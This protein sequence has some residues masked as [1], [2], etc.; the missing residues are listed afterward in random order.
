MKRIL[1][2]ISILFYLSTNAQSLKET[3]DW[4]KIAVESNSSCFLTVSPDSTKLIITEEPSGDLQIGVRQTIPLKMIRSAKFEQDSSH[5]R[6]DLKCSEGRCVRAEFKFPNRSDY[7]PSASQDVIF[8]SIPFN[9]S[10]EE[11]MRQR[12]IKA[13]NHL[14]SLS[15]GASLDNKF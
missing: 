8:L 3:L 12:I 11:K 9:F 1:S 6:I 13:F 4:I 2:L 15:G 14:I 10:T 5:L 7:T